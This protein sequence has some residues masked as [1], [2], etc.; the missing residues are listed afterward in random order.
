MTRWITYQRERFPLLAHGPLVAAFSVSAV[1]FS[2]LVRGEPGLPPPAS[3]VVAF[4]TALIF[5]L[6]L[7]ITDEFKDFEDDAR[8]RPYRPVP[9]GLVTL[10][11]LGWIGVGGAAIQ[12]A[13]ALW[14]HPP[15]VALL[16]L[17]WAYL[18]L[19]SREFFAAEWLRRRPA[20]YMA[21]HMVIIPLID[22]YATACDWLP[23]T[24][25]PP[26]GLIWFLLVSYV[27]GIVVEVG[28][29]TR[30]PADEEPGVETYSSAWGLTTAV[31]VWVAALVV[32]AVLAWQAAR[33]IGFAAPMARFLIVLVG[34]STLAAMRLARFRAPGTGK[35]VELASGIWTLLLYLSLGAIP[36]FIAAR[37]AS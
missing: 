18:A 33:Q 34:V 9:R 35:A 17:A 12:L 22:L 25:W 28:R 11:E 14:L 5:F 29:K 19:M 13:L 27:N 23:V 3:L 6:Q 30:A 31:S 20:I 32:T 7:R 2:R 4:V 8:Y 10:R 16:V 37:G 36:A 26:P 21:S 24:G 15:L 1:C